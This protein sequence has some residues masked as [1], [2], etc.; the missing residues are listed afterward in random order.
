[1]PEEVI[2]VLTPE[3]EACPSEQTE[4]SEGSVAAGKSN[5]FT[6]LVAV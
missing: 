6:F 2:V 3:A 5:T 1:M 4:I